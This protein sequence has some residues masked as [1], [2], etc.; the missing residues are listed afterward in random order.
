[1]SNPTDRPPAIDVVAKALWVLSH[2]VLLR[3]IDVTEI[4][5]SQPAMSETV[6]HTDITGYPMYRD[7]LLDAIGA[8]PPEV[9]SGVHGR[10]RDWRGNLLTMRLLITE[11]LADEDGAIPALVDEQPVAEG[12]FEPG[13]SGPGVGRPGVKFGLTPDEPDES[14]GDEGVKT[15]VTPDAALPRPAPNSHAELLALVDETE[16]HPP[17]DGPGE[18]TRDLMERYAG[19]ASVVVVPG[20]SS[21]EAVHAAWSDYARARAL[22]DLDGRTFPSKAEALTAVNAWPGRDMLEPDDADAVAAQLV[23]ASLAAQPPEAVKV[24]AQRGFARIIP[25]FRREVPTR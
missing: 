23:D 6:V 1:M 9:W 11:Q 12:W 20:P 17:A 5:H 2:L 4:W 7:A 21:D 8:G 19:V 14:P 24:P 13:N 16:E 22:C 10:W 25:L 18:D 3:R 15:D